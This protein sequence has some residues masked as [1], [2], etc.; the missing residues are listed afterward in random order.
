MGH[1]LNF[2]KKALWINFKLSLAHRAAFIFTV[3]ITI[4]K[5]ILF[6][7][8]WQFFFERHKRVHGWNFDH[9]LVA[10]GCFCFACG[11]VEGFFLGLKEIPRMVETGQLDSFLLQ[12]KNIILNIAM[13]KGDI[14]A[15]GEL[16][17]GILLISYSG[18]WAI[19]AVEIILFLILAVLFMFSLLL[20]LSCLSFFVK[21]SFDFIRELNL[22]AVIVATQPNAAY[23]G[24]L[25]MLTF[26][27][28]PVAFLSFYPVEFLRTG[29]GY[30]LFL[31]IAGTLLFLSMSCWIFHL[32]LKRYESGNIIGFRQ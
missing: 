1:Q 22:N 2:L 9:L 11:T 12:P 15:F 17:T 30:Y 13:S 23:R 7:V 20:Y 14:S 29:V 32:G 6:L 25:K 16:V 31:S 10:Y 28:L 4:V 24:F 26:T 19:F 18:Y 3:V 8:M 21:N 27:I 5:Q